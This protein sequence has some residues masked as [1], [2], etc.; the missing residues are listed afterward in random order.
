L[1]TTTQVAQIQ[2]ASDFGNDQFS[3]VDVAN[4]FS[5]NGD[6]M[7][8]RIFVRG[9]GVA[10]MTWTIYNRWGAVVYQSTDPNEGWDGKVNGNCSHRKYI[11]I[12]YGRIWQ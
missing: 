9:F 6:G 10:K 3:L 4:S 5:P 2:P 1:F 12:H 8:D 11:I 7:N